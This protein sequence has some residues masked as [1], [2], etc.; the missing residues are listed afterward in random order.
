MQSNTKNLFNLS[1]TLSWILRHAAVKLKLDISSDGYVKI[2]DLLKLSQL[3]GYD[4]DDVFDVVEDN[5]KKRFAIKKENNTYYIRANQGHS[6]KVA[7]RIKQEE[8]LQKLDDPLDLVVHGTT[9]EAY[10]KIS[11]SGLK[12]MGRSHIHFAISTDFT[13]GN[14]QQSGIRSNCELIIYLDM[15]KAMN[16]GIEFFMS[17][18]KVVLSPGIGNEGLIPK[19]YFLKVVDRKTNKIID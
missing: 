1:K 18:N 15:E 5:A 6:N 17:Q 14:K 7:S 16:D 4:I 2:D 8:L 11:K 13:E 3:K 10:E 19:E 9:Y 12:K